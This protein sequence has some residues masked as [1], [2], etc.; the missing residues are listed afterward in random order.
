[1]HSPN[2]LAYSVFVKITRVKSFIVYARDE[3]DNSPLLV[4]DT[5]IQM[6]KKI[7]VCSIGATTF[8]IMTFSI[9]MK[10]ATISVTAF[11][12]NTVSMAKFSITI[13]KCDT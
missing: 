9:T 11:C 12:K 1:M 4:L 6:F 3:N 8:S 7:G 10:N 2:A 5:Y 13:R